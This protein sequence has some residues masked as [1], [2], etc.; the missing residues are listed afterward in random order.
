MVLEVVVS[1]GATRMAS[2]PLQPPAKF[3][4]MQLPRRMAEVEKALQAV[5]HRIGNGW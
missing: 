3:N 4:F 1:T 2:V 5:P